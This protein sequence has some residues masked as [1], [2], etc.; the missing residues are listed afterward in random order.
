MKL[1][2]KLEGPILVEVM[3]EVTLNVWDVL[4]NFVLAWV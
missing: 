2:Y 4:E 1:V 3:D